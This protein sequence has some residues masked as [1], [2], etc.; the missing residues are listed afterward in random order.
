MEHLPSYC[1]DLDGTLCTNTFGD[2]QNA[3]P[4]LDAINVVNSLFE[5][6]H[7]IKIYTARGTGSGFDWFDKTVSQLNSWNLNY[8]EL[9][10]G[11]PEADVYIDDRGISASDWFSKSILTP[12]TG[13]AYVYSSLLEASNVMIKNSGLAGK[14]LEACELVTSCL[15]SGNKILWCG[16]GGSAA[17]SQHL[18]A[19]LVGRFKFNRPALASLALTTDTSILTALGND[20]GFETIFARQVEALGKPG[21]VLIGISTSGNSGN[22]FNALETAKRMKISTIAFTGLANCQLDA[23]DIVLK[24]PTHTTSHIQECHICWGQI[25]C[26]YAESTLFTN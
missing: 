25:I 6:G 18:A 5:L 4:I 24:A 13:L 10:F 9:V 15:K 23:A 22:V 3:K 26:G 16:N 1:F 17:D 21:D 8:H 2:Y 19:E 20:F 12:K 11:K 14:L 7:Q